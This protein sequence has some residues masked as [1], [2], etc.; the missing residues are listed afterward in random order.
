MADTW[1]MALDR[2]LRKAEVPPDAEVE[3]CRTR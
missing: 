1:R 2:L 3:R